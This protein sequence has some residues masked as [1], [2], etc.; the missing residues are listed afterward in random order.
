MKKVL[1]VGSSGGL[2]KQ[3]IKYFNE[4]EYILT[5][6][7]SK[8]LDI[9]NYQEVKSFFEKGGYDIVINLSGKNID[10]MVHKLEENDID[11]MID[12]NIKGNI[13]LLRFCLPYM[14]NNNYGRIILISSV[15]SEV[16]IP[17]TSL[18]SGSKSFIDS[19]VK[20]T[21][22]ENISK[23]ITCN[24]IQLGYFDGGMC[25]DIPSNIQENIKNNIGL[26]RWGKIVE[27]YSTIEYIINTEYITGQN[28]RIDGGFKGI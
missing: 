15:L 14:R 23:K 19:I 7:S 11:K 3:V 20:T 27:L 4:N 5:N 2:G 12:V 26:K 10:G 28:I 24:S 18:Y 9:T 6:L 22:S 25:H 13:N 16:V 1:I 17:G 21:S 8:D